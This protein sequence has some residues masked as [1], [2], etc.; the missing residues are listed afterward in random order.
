LAGCASATVLRITQV[1]SCCSVQQV[2]YFCACALPASAKAAM[3]YGDH[4]KTNI[5]PSQDGEAPSFALTANRVVSPRDTGPQSDSLSQPAL[6]PHKGSDDVFIGAFPNNVVFGGDLDFKLLFAPRL[7][8]RQKST[9]R[10][11]QL[12]T[13]CKQGGVTARHRA[14]V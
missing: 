6:V 3:E 9:W 12:C 5:L 1:G 2:L 14:S 11:P 10:S 7:K 4:N 8:P 13:Y